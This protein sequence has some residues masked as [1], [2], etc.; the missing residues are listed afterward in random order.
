MKQDKTACSFLVEYEEGIAV[1]ASCACGV[2]FTPPKDID[3]ASE[4]YFFE[5]YKKHYA[6]INGPLDL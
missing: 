4:E 1:S 6:K 3:S 5:Q 2:T